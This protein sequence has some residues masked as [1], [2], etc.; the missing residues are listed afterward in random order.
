MR[1][2]PVQGRVMASIETAAAGPTRPDLVRVWDLPV[3]VFHWSL[4]G[5]VALSW[6]SAEN[7]YLKLH[8]WSGLIVLTLL[9]FRIAWGLVGSTTARFSNFV[10]GPKP[11]LAYLQ[12]TVRGE[13]HAH[14]GHN[15]AGGWMVMVLLAVL[16]LQAGTGLFANDGVRFNGPLAAQVSSGWSDRLTSLHGTVFNVVLLLVWM[17]VVAALYYR[18]VRG[19]NQIAAMISGMKPRAEIPPD[20]AMEFVHYR[21]A[22]L[23]LALAAVLVWW[24]ASS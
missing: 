2:S 4:A 16:L 6:V 18:Y 14:A 15:P 11:A 12:A 1:I 5:L 23:W 17:H 10:R 24:I 3:R 13:R 7:G 9:L 22:L 8:L 21:W 20:A 19:E